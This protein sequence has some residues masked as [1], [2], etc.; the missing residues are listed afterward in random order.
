MRGSKGKE[1]TRP[2]SQKS[3]RGKKKLLKPGGTK[4]NK[5]KNR[6]GVGDKKKKK[7]LNGVTNKP[8][9]AEDEQLR[10]VRSGRT[11]GGR[12]QKKRF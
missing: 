4:L 6:R 11:G 3:E 9:L 10:G 5:E 2:R 12:K 1:K 8:V 7:S